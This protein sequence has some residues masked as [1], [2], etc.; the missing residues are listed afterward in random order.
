MKRITAL[1]GVA[2]VAGWLIC[3]GTQID[4]KPPQPLPTG[5]TII[6]NG[7][8][9]RDAQPDSIYYT[10]LFRSDST[11]FGGPG[12][13][14]VLVMVYGNRALYLL[15]PEAPH[16][17]PDSTTKPEDEYDILWYQGIPVVRFH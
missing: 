3:C 12:A 14:P 16:G 13:V 2:A 1:F 8:I 4:V 15:V 7:T 9:P 5:T 11:A 17:V 6:E 10:T